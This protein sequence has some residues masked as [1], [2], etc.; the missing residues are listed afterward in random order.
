MG[1]DQSVVRWRAR[2]VARWRDLPEERFSPY[3]MAKQLYYR[4][5]EQGVLDQ[6]FEAI[7]SDPNLEWRVI[8]ATVTKPRLWAARG[9]VYRR[10]GIGEDRDPE[11]GDA[12]HRSDEEHCLEPEGCG[13]VLTNV[14]HR[15]PGQLNHCWDVC[16]PVSQD[17]W[18]CRFQC[19]IGT[20]SHCYPDA[21]LFQRWGIIYA[22][23]DH[24]HTAVCAQFA[25][26]F[27]LSSGIMSAWNGTPSSP[28]IA[29]LVAG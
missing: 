20:G 12:N 26:R 27:S 11:T 19:H 9:A 25:D 8:D 1:K 15:T 24:H 2:S 21:R 22:I 7:E 16:H 13:N 29:A 23:A 17:C 4:W 5:L 6:L 14:R 28:A 3:Q 18:V 10:S